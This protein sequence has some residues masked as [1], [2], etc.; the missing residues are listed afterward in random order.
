M[1]ERGKKKKKTR[2]IITAHTPT[3]TKQFLFAKATPI[4]F[5]FYCVF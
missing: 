5:F 1:P 4:L 3:Q 2:K